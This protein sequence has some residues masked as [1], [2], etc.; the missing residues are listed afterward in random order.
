MDG[1]RYEWCDR[2]VGGF[3]SFRCTY[4]TRPTPCFVCE[5]LSL[6]SVSSDQVSRLSL[7]G[8]MWHGRLW[9]TQ[10]FKSVDCSTSATPTAF[11]V[12]GHSSPGAG[13]RG[14]ADQISHR[15]IQLQKIFSQNSK[16]RM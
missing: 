15:E 12:C 9:E 14:T 1:A 4:G 3:R 5:S 7:W 13:G 11:F 6:I 10:S 2:W 8:D 16:A